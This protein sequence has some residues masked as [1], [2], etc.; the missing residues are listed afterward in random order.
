MLW[1]LSQLPSSG[2]VGRR[3][4]ASHNRQVASR[5]SGVPSQLVTSLPHEW[6][7]LPVPKI[8]SDFGWTFSTVDGVINSHPLLLECA[9]SQIRLLLEVR[10]EWNRPRQFRLTLRSSLRSVGMSELLSLR[11]RSGIPP[12][13][14]TLDLRSY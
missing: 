14:Q 7:N 1:Q 13:F 4:L 6:Q 10:N 12:N 11:L 3:P 2:C 8:N 9:E 5:C